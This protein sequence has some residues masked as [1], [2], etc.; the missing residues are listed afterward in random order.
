[1]IR[2]QLDDEVQDKDKDCVEFTIKN[3]FE[4]EIRDDHFSD[5]EKLI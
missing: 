1:M 5:I 2:G 4:G 3:Y